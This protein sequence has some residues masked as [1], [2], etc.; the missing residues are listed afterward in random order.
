MQLKKAWLTAPGIS[1]RTVPVNK[2]LTGLCQ[3]L[4]VVFQLIHV[5]G[6]AD[7]PANAAAE[8]NAKRTGEYAHQTSDQ[9]AGPARRLYR[10]AGDKAVLQEKLS[11]LLLHNSCLRNRKAFVVKILPQHTQ[12]LIS[13]TRYLTV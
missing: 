11:G 4:T 3:H 9:A 7:Q 6:L 2:A 8:Q 12:Y 5:H 13:F 1:N 10:V